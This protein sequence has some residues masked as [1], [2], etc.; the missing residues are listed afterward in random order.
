MT[1]PTDTAIWRVRNMDRAISTAISDEAAARHMSVAEYLAALLAFVHACRENPDPEC[2]GSGAI[3]A[4]LD[5]FGLA[6]VT[7]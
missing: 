5:K 1:E 2:D 6:P 7:H 3:N 4:Y